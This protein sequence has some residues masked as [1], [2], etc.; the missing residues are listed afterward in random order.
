[1]TW[2]AMI[3]FV[4]AAGGWLMCGRVGSL[5][6]AAAALVQVADL[7]GGTAAPDPARAA[8]AA[9]EPADTAARLASLREL[10]VPMRSIDPAD[11]DFSDLMPLVER[12]GSARIVQLGEQSHGDGAAFYAKTRLIRFLHE[13]MG[14]DVLAWESGLFDCR[15]V[16]AA[17]REGVPLVEAAERGV[18]AIWSHSGQVLPLFE[19]VRSTLHTSRP[20]HTAGFDCQF[21][22]PATWPRYRAYLIDKLGRPECNLLTAE[23]LAALDRILK[24]LEDS[25]NR[26]GG[27]NDPGARRAQRLAIEELKATVQRRQT[28]LLGVLDAPEI[29]FLCRTL[30]NLLVFE[31]LLSQPTSA[32]PAANNIRDRAM[33]ENLAWLAERVYPDRKIVVWAASFHI[34]RNAPTV[35]GVNDE[36]P[37]DTTVPMGEAVLTR[38]AGRVYS[39]AFCAYRGKAGRMYERPSELAEAE[40]GTLEWLLH[41]LEQPYL[42]VDF[43]GLPPEHWLRGPVVAGPLGYSPMRADWTQVF[44]AI[45]FTDVMFPS[46]TG[47][48]VPDGVK[49]RRPESGKQAEPDGGPPPR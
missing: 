15:E 22:S 21:S 48:E 17:L 23:R 18:F 4:F 6:F 9:P 10:A 36:T 12:I 46:T 3:R 32:D 47:G 43:R 5:C 7:P 1:M 38:F 27:Q 29:E 40:P 41:Q 20:L 24:R 39:V 19:Y 28:D 26:A 42:F 49:V 8:A 25:A 45:M 31:E 2:S 11:D 14:F 30:Q 37:Y 16:D 34:M 44:D 13:V 33:A 35:K